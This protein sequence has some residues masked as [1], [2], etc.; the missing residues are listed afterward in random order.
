MKLKI[1]LCTAL[2]SIGFSVAAHAATWTQLSPTTSPVNV[3]GTDMYY[4]PSPA[5]EIWYYNDNINPQSPANIELEVEDV[6]GTS[7]DF[8]G[9]CDNEGCTS[10]SVAEGFESKAGVFGSEVGFNYLAIHFGKGELF[11]RWNDLI[12]E[13]AFEGLPKDLSNFRAYTDN[14]S[15][16]PVPAAA[17]LLGSALLGFVGYRR[18]S[19]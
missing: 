4:A 18:R 3:A 11:F 12:N 13:F 15:Q 9:A 19:H 2:A 6:F 8:V 5:A 14:P 17:W 1:A 7:V 10:G 16:V